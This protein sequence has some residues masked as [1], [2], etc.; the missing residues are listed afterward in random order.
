MAHEN[1]WFPD[2]F[3]NCKI[4]SL[5]EPTP[6]NW[7]VF[8]KINEH[9]EQWQDVTCRLPSLASAKFVCRDA[10]ESPNGPTAFLRIVKQI[11]SQVAEQ[12]TRTEPKASQAIRAQEATQFTPPELKAYQAL[13]D[14]NSPNTPKLLAW[15]QGTQDASGTVPGGFIT[16]VIF[17]DIEGIALGDENGAGIYWEQPPET[18]AKIREIGI[19]PIHDGPG[20]LIWNAERETIH[21]V[22]FEDPEFFQRKGRVTAKIFPRYGLAKTPPGDRWWEYEVN[23]DPDTSKWTF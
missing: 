1:I 17:E 10:S 7:E 6:S 4:L 20:N 23:K 15:Q 13:K 9:V 2:P 5:N 19:L 22:G 11:P 16:W 12:F 21:F 8:Q 18:R 3:Q 14:R